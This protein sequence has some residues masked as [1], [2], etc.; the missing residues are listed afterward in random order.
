MSGGIHFRGLAPGQ[1][2]NTASTKYG[3]GGEAL[4][5]LSDLTAMGIKPRPLESMAMSSALLH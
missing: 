1:Q 2:H 5:T 3:S 4:A